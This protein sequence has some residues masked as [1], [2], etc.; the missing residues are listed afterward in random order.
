MGLVNGAL[1]GK[2]LS[3]RAGRYAQRGAIMAGSRA[4]KHL[5]NV[6]CAKNAQ[7]QNDT[8]NTCKVCRF[9]TPAKKIGSKNA[10]KRAMKIKLKN[11]TRKCL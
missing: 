10:S 11:L 1:L 9:C 5:S 8:L 2:R 6:K 7:R 3:G 4:E